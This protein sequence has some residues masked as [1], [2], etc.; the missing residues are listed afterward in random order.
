MEPS[1]FEEAYEGQAPWDV[2]RPQAAIVRAADAGRIQGSVLD[3][4][5]GT[6]EN[7]LYLAQQGH[8]VWGVDLVERAIGEA[9]R[10]ARER[11]LDARF[12]ELDALELTELDRTFDTV[13]DSG[14][15]H[16][17]D[18]EDRERYDEMLGQV[19]RPGGRYVVLCFSD[20]E[21]GDWGPR[22]ISETELRTAFASG[23]TVASIEPARFEIRD[24]PGFA[25][26][27]LG[28]MLR[29]PPI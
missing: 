4:G 12:F 5:C 22:R 26:A 13:V 2:G 6:G 21:P 1:R 14:L 11:G 19:L 25:H 15:F 7:A 29:E 27:W 8:Y 20:L 17:F 24:D 3:V 9:R 16:V 23:W 18:D 10:K 28:V